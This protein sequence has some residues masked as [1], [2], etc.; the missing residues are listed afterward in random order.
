[1]FRDAGTNPLVE[2]LERVVTELE[3]LADPGK[4][5]RED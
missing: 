2:E 3:K 5:L 1:V 4:L